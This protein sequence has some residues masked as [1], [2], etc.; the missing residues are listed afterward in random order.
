MHLAEEPMMVNR[1]IPLLPCKCGRSDLRMV[2]TSFPNMQGVIQCMSCKTTGP[3]NN[4]RELISK[5]WN[6]LQLIT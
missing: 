2:V 1:D 3:M 6:T 5:S 4:T